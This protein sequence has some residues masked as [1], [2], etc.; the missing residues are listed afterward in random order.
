MPVAENISLKGDNAVD[1]QK[2][3]MQSITPVVKEDKP[4]TKTRKKRAEGGNEKL[5]E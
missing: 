2:K 1:S 4:V 5:N 3:D